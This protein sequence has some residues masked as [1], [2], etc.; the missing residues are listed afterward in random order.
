MSIIDYRNS[1]KDLYKRDDPHK[2]NRAELHLTNSEYKTGTLVIQFWRGGGSMI[3]FSRREYFSPR[4]D[5][6]GKIFSQEGK[7]EM[8]DREKIS[9]QIS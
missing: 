5:K 3:I 6:K 7:F 8:K 9:K 2:V 1:N 4:K